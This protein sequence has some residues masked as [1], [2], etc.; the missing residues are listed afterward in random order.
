MKYV[1]Q[2]AVILAVSCAG[3][4][5]RY[6]VPLP[7]PASIYGLLIMFALLC[8]GVIKLDSVKET[9]G[10]LL[11]I[12]PM[13]FIPAAVGLLDSWPQLRPVVLPFAAITLTT[14]VLVMVVTGRVAQRL[15]GRGA[16]EEEKD[17]E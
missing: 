8:A 3:E 13:L 7:I 15:M 6:F 14:T 9:G 10:L 12:M 4:I 5:I 2:A 16:V 11:E 1:K 17:D